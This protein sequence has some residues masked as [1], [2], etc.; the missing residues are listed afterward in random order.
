MKPAKIADSSAAHWPTQPI[1]RAFRFEQH[2]PVAYHC[3]A[4]VAATVAIVATA[5]ISRA[6]AIAMTAV[7]VVL[8]LRSLLRLLGDPIAEVLLT[9]MNY[10]GT[11]AA[12]GDPEGSDIAA[13][14]AL[15]CI[16]YVCSLVV[17][18]P[19]LYA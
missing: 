8:A 16:F 4:V 2:R 13:G 6:V 3:I 10:P 9:L 12:H 5:A 19:L 18:S 17:V 7:L 11:R 15:E 14:R 1:A